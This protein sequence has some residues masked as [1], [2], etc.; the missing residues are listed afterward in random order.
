[1][2]Y[3]QRIHPRKTAVS[4]DPY[5]RVAVQ[6]LKAQAETPP[7]SS[8]SIN[9]RGN[10]LVMLAATRLETLSP[11]TSCRLVPL[12]CSPRCVGR[13]SHCPLVPAAEFGNP[14][15][16]PPPPSRWISWRPAGITPRLRHPRP[17]ERRKA[18]PCSVLAGDSWSRVRLFCSPPP[19]APPPP[20]HRL[21]REYPRRAFDFVALL[22]DP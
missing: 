1:M 3:I 6:P 20:G 9:S 2:I 13:W 12:V 10:F 11:T 8:N 16:S 15:S 5:P 17:V 22:G 19:R 7:T 18:T 4:L 21:P 14:S